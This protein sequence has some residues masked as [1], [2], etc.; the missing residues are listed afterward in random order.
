MEIELW[1]DFILTGWW[2]ATMEFYDLS[3][4]GNFIIPTDFHSIIFQ[5]GRA[6]HH[7]PDKI[8][9][10]FDGPKPM[11]TI[12]KTPKFIPIFACAGHKTQPGRRLQRPKVSWAGRSKGLESLEDFR[13]FE[14]LKWWFSLEMMDVFRDLSTT[15]ENLAIMNYCFH[16]Q[17]EEFAQDICGTLWNNVMIEPTD[18][19]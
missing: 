11:K 17:N 12:H 19:D 7:Q 10:E 6:K 2:F 4:I 9:W 3:Y 1:I 5:R 16:H 14:Q 8:C 15:S 18:S 13:V